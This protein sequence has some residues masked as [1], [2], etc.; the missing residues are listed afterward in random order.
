MKNNPFLPSLTSEVPYRALLWCAEGAGGGLTLQN[1]K[2][3]IV[4]AVLVQKFSDFKTQI[5]KVGKFF[6]LVQ[7][8]I[9]DGRFVKTKTF[10]ER[11]QINNLRL[12]CLLELH[13]VVKNPREEMK[14]WEKVKNVYRVYIHIET[15]KNDFDKIF[16]LAKKNG[17]QLGLAINPETKTEKLKN[18]LN[19]IDAVLFMTVHP[20]IQGQ[21]LMAPVLKKIKT[22]ANK[23]KK[24]LIAADGGISLENIRAV[25][26]AG[27][28]EFC[29][30]KRLIMAGDIKKVKIQ[31][32]KILNIKY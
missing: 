3:Q 21:K 2:S 25:K 27:V 14:K 20:G 30:G 22:F 6:S 31:F 19:K 29:I 26:N 8:D 5:K 24:I 32:E 7:I 16:S 1:M 13:L 18:Y 28:R 9:G 23:N 4:P 10:R 12:P 15:L 17:W 11:Q